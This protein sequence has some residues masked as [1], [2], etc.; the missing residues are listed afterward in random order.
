MSV[1]SFKNAKYLPRCPLQEKIAH[2]SKAEEK[3]FHTF[4]QSH[5][6]VLSHSCVV[7]VALLL[8][9]AIRVMPFLELL[10]SKEMREKLEVV[11]EQE[12]VRREVENIWKMDLERCEST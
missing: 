2:M 5:S 1:T 12:R 7:S 10:Q 4:S 3:N 6:D 11:K 9:F 8:S